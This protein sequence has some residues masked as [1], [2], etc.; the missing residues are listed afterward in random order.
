MKE[1]R[2]IYIDLGAGIMILWMIIYHAINMAWGYELNEYWN[3]TDLSQLP[4]GLHAI[5]GSDGRIKKLN[6]CVIFPY[7]SFFMP[8][9]F[10]KSGQFF[11]KRSVSD[12]LIKDSKKLLVTFLIWSAVGYV[13]LLLFESLDHT[14]T[15]RRATYSIARGLLLTGKIPIN[16]PLWFL[17]TLFGVRFFANLTLPQKDD[18]KGW[19][20]A[21]GLAAIGYLIAYSAYRVNNYLLPLWVANGAAGY[22]FFVLGYELREYEKKWWVIAPCVIVYAICCFAGFQMVDMMYNEIISGNYMLWMPVALCSIITFNA[23]CR[24]VA[25]YVSLKPIEIVGRYA[26]PIYVTHLLI[27][28]TVTFIIRF[29]KLTFF[30][31]YLLWVILGSYAIF[32]PVFCRI[33]F[34]F[35]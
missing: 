19:V 22:S 1:E 12:L 6:P 5:M 21:L 24:L 30:E 35:S 34:K 16:E 33:P 11:D 31:P 9:F 13:L 10:Y 29:E 32:L 15:L 3:L 20:K 27:V 4:D 28:L 7:L 8:W 23:F 18:S 14:L 2:L 17:V 26:M 25:E